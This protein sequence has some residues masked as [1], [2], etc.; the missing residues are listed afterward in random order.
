MIRCG[1]RRERGKPL[2]RTIGL[3]WRSSSP[4]TE[5]FLLIAN[6]LRDAVKRNFPDFML[7]E[8]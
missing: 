3:A 7:H 5:T 6:Y 1:R 2:H 8:L 4:Q